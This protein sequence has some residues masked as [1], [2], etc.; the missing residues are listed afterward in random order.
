M[1][2]IFRK[3]R[4]DLFYRG[5]TRKYLKYAIGEI[6]LVVIGILIALQINTLNEARKLSKVKQNYYKQILLDLEADKHYA[7]ITIEKIDASIE[8]YNAYNESFKK[9]NLPVSEIIENLTKNS[10]N[11]T[12]FQFQTTTIESLITSG[13]IKFLDSDIRNSLT[14]YNGSKEIIHTIYSTNSNFYTDIMKEVTMAGYGLF[15]RFENQKELQRIVDDGQRYTVMWIKLDAFHSWK[16][17]N[18]RYAVESLTEL[19]EEIN[20][21]VSL[22]NKKLEAE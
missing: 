9:P 15:P 22:I 12:I 17:I 13:E 1:I 18:E 5:Q 20:T 7:E 6:V 10:I 16:T 4:Q 19:L 2:K 8:K 3:I 14:N 11:T 21:V